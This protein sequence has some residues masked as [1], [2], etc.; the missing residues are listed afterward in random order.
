[1]P[2]EQHSVKLFQHRC[3]NNDQSSQEQRGS[4]LSN[5]MTDV[6]SWDETRETDV[7]DACFKTVFVFIGGDGI[8]SECDFTFGDKRRI[9]MIL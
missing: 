5:A 3:K 2:T 9:E 6:T 7:D 8:E 4:C 1:M